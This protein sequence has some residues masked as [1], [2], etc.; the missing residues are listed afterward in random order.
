[1]LSHPAL[2]SFVCCALCCVSMQLGAMD[3][4]QGQPM[5]GKMKM[6]FRGFAILIVPLTASFPKVRL[7]E[8]CRNHAKSE[9]YKIMTFWSGVIN[10]IQMF[11]FT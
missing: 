4:M 5:M 10:A 7:S 9:L 2:C 11:R 1:M 8:S 3:G 6:F